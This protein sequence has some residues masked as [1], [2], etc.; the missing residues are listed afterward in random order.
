MGVTQKLLV[1]AAALSLSACSMF[2]GK[3]TFMTYQDLQTKVRE[4]D[5]EI[6]AVQDQLAQ[7]KQTD[8]ANKPMAANSASQSNNATSQSNSDGL[9]L[10]ESETQAAPSVAPQVTPVANNQNQQMAPAQSSPAQSSAQTASSQ[11]S[12][13]QAAPM[14]SSEPKALTPNYNNTPSVAK[15]TSKASSGHN[16]YGVQLA[17]YTSRQEAV[18]GWKRLS[19]NNSDVFVNLTPHINQAVV[20]GRTMYQLKVGPFL[21][22][23]YSVGFCNMLKQKGKDCIVKK[24]DGEPL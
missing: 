23:A 9:G 4:H 20:N 19:K 18:N 17:A 6:K 16:Q 21:D 3:N 8:S 10:S 7:L 1:V 12:S 13:M 5:A 2:E 15:T 22:R 24:F 14:S 11:S